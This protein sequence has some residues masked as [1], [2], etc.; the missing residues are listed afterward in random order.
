MTTRYWLTC[1]AVAG[2]LLLASCGD[3]VQSTVITDPMTGEQVRIA[4]GDNMAVPRDLPDFAPLYPGARIEQVMG[5]T[6]A[7]AAGLD[8]GGMVGFRT[9]DEPTQVAAFYRQRLDASGLPE[10]TEAMMDGTYILVAGSEDFS[11]NVRLTIAPHESGRGSY[12][13]MVYST[14]G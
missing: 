3:D 14:P 11:R 12:V 8:R 1:L 2:A 6:A 9:S 7:A 13:T 5:T 10:R 4:S